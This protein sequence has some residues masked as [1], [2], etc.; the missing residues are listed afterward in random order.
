MPGPGGGGGGGDPTTIGA[1]RAISWGTAIRD[2]VTTMAESLASAA[3]AEV[4]ATLLSS[5]DCAQDA[6]DRT[7]TARPIERCWRLMANSLFSS[8]A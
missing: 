5:T 1:L 8:A 7:A 4:G 2:P 6:R 3:G